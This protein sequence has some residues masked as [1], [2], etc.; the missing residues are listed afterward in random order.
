MDTVMHLQEAVIRISQVPAEDTS[1]TWHDAD[2]L[3]KQAAEVVYCGRS[4]RVW[5]QLLQ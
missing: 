3:Q 4:G 5:P 2:P 1:E